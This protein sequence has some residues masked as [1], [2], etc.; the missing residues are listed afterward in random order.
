MGGSG[1]PGSLP[2]YAVG[3]ARSQVGAS[4][5]WQ[6]RAACNRANRALSRV[7]QGAIW[8]ESGRVGVGPS[9]QVASMV[10]HSPGRAALALGP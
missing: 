3:G 9:R 4:S 10:Q 7:E 5:R 8:V 1:T 2:K 6:K